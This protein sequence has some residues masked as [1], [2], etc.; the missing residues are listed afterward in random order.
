MFKA[1]D[2]VILIHP[3]T[4]SRA[5]V[6]AIGV[7][8]EEDWGSDGSC[9]VRFNNVPG[10]SRTWTQAIY[11]INLAPALEFENREMIKSWFGV[12]DEV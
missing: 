8:T 10:K 7:V 5:P 1:G 9:V 4:T 3:D 11:N 12:K 6:G 2:R